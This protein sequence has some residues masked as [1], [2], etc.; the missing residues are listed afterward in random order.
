MYKF[1]LA[2]RY[3]LRRKIS[4]F[5]IAAVA[6]CVFVVFIVITIVAGI[7]V[8]FK[9]KVYNSIGDCVIHTKSLVGFGHYEEFIEQLQNEPYVYAAAPLVKNYAMVSV[10]QETKEIAGIE[11]VSFSKVTGF[12]DWIEY[13]KGDVG[14]VFQPTYDVNLPGCVPGIGCYFRR[15]EDGGYDT[16]EQLR[17]IALEFNCIPLNAKGAMSRLGAGDFS[18]KTFYY[19]DHFR[20]GYSLDWKRIFLPLEEAQLLCGMGGPDKRVTHIH[21][22]FNEGIGLEEGTS[23]VK[24]IWGKYLEQKKGVI[25]YKLLENVQVDS[26]KNFSK[27][28]VAMAE[29]Q[30]TMI[31]ICFFLIGIITAFIVLVVFYMVVSHKSKDIGI[32][33][34]VGAGQVSI[35]S[36][37]LSFG[38][39]IGVLGSAIGALIGWPFIVYINEI[40]DF[41]NIQLWDK[42]YS[43]ILVVPNEIDPKVLSVIIISAIGACLLGALLPSWRAAR[44]KCVDTLQVTQL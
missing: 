12:A 31:I 4:Y 30:Q 29:T 43:S 8:N 23:K 21:I 22:K 1:K 34:S 9:G 16:P 24:E 2:L 32:L 27:A 38:F 40:F 36:L 19:S 13:H 14:N 7:T 33:K 37:F 18:S 10:D 20:A 26:W 6:L 15:N 42:R 5:A 3:L 11:P 25:N 41:F 44:M 17:Q 39:M 28:V 35:L